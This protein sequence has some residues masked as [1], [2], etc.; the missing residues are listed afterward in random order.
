MKT[1]NI[2]A[3]I[4]VYFI[5]VNAFFAMSENGD[6][7][8][9]SLRV[10]AIETSGNSKTTRE[11]I[12]TNID[13]S[14]GDRIDQQQLDRNYRQLQ[15]TNFF[16]KVNLYTQ[17]G[18]NRGEVKV[19][20]EV[21]E[22][23]WPYFQIKGGFSELDGWYVSPLGLRFD[24]FFGSGNY[25]GAEMLIGDR[26]TGLDIFFLRPNFM[27]SGLNFRVLLLARNRQFVHY[28]SGNKFLQDVSGAG[29][30]FRFNGTRG[31]MK[32]L[33]FEYLTESFEPK[34]YMYPPG[35][36]GDHR[37]LP[38]VL[39]LPTERQNVGRI[40]VS[41]Y[42]DTRDRKFYPGSG[43]WGSLSLDQASKQFG[44][45][46][47]YKKAILD[48]RRYQTLIGNVVLAARAKGGWIDDE[49]PFYEKFYLGGPNSLRG[50]A[51]RSLNPLGYASR[52]VQGSV[53]LRFPV[54]QKNYPSHLVTGVVFYDIGQAWS[55]P[56]DF[57]RKNFKS[58]VGYGLRF[59]LPIIGLLRADFAY[60][61]P[62]YDFRFHLSLGQT[63]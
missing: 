43:W 62:D 31:I 61:V 53:E 44:G 14:V 5:S 10:Q 21:E 40:R 6:D 4:L 48:I 54:T 18:D 9:K 60:D 45:D 23:S 58:G 47:D 1:K 34:P 11:V 15:Q 41:L 46:A 39:Q 12:L 32:Y 59:K 42:A 52:L 22:R 55:E 36:K 56:D 27:N 63:F 57:D 25:M 30:S 2:I 19:F 50:Y 7:S 51:D 29:L 16:K 3:V 37:N 13:F 35:E 33:W 24:N 20:I 17:P 28:I 38:P 8:Q 49:A 26:T